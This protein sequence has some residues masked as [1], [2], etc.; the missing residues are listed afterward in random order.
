MKSCA[1]LFSGGLDS[2]AMAI[3]LRREG[4]DVV[5]VYMSHRANG[6]NVTKKEL[7]TAAHLAKAL[8]GHGLAIVKKPPTRRGDDA[9]YTEW[10]DVYYSRRMPISKEKKGRRNK[11]FLQVAKQLGFDQLD[12]IALGTLGVAGESEFVGQE[13]MRRVSRQRLNDVTHEKLEATLEPGQ[14]ITLESLGLPGKVAMLKA[15]GHGK[16]ARDACYASESCLMYFAKPCG[17]CSSCKSRAKAFMA[18]W[19]KDKT[20]YRRGSSAD[21]VKR[22]KVKR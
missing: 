12:F 19:G 2:V 16:K 3:L 7:T 15:V 17:N 14:L 1:L 10:G 21:L 9:W 6:G 11:I 18:A 13:R 20:P 22:G 4:L 5:P 8:T